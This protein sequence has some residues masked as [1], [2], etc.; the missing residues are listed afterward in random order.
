MTAVDATDLLARSLSSRSRFTRIES[1]SST[2]LSDLFTAF[3]RLRLAHA[4]LLRSMII[5]NQA[6]HMV[7]ELTPARTSSLILNVT[8]CS[9]DSSY[10]TRNRATDPPKIPRAARPG[11]AALSHVSSDPDRLGK[12]M[13]RIVSPLL[14]V[15]AWLVML[16]LIVETFRQRARARKRRRTP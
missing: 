2:M 6:Q 16:A 10:R 11:V 4:V 1:K 12:T 5:N 13:R 15:T 3:T 8:C 7:P 9:S 14:M